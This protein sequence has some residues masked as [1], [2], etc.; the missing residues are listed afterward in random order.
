ME[1]LPDVFAPS[2]GQRE[3]PLRIETDERVNHLDI[4]FERG[5]GNLTFLRE[6]VAGRQKSW[7][8]R[9]SG[10]SAGQYRI[11]VEARASRNGPLLA[12]TT[13]EITVALEPSVPPERDDDSDGLPDWWEIAHGLN[14]EDNG[15]MPGSAGNGPAGDPDGDGVLIPWSSSWDWIPMRLTGEHFRGSGFPVMRGEGFGSYLPVYQT[16]TTGSPG[17]QTSRTGP[18]W[19]RLLTLALTSF[20]EPTRSWTMIFLMWG[21]GFTGWKL[22]CPENDSRTCLIRPV[23][24]IP[25]GKKRQIARVP[26]QCR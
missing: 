21:K 12:T 24:Q 4:V 10:V 23:R 22:R 2:P 8:Y 11:R 25:C 5:T 1:F 6:D 13:R 26:R 7:D 16:A 19:K 20:P 14:T 3:I 18:L 17:V 9:W 15:S